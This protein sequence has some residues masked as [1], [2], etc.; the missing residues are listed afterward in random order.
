MAQLTIQGVPVSPLGLGTW[1]LTGRTCEHAVAEAI[2]IGYRHIDTAQ[3]YG[4]EAEVGAGIA[5]S[6]I[7]PAELFVTTKLWSN[8]LTPDAVRCSTEESLRQL[9]LDAVDLLLIHHPFRPDIL[10]DTLGAMRELRDDGLVRHLGVS[11]FSIDLLERA[12][13]STELLA[14]QIEYHPF[15]RQ[16]D[17]LAAARR[18]DLLFQAYSPLARGG[19]T[20]TEV[21]EEVARHLGATAPQVVLRW[22]ID[23]HNV[24]PIPKASSRAHLEENWGALD[25]KLDDDARARL[26]SLTRR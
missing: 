23:Q 3:M 20:G 1:Q 24:V 7:D 9:R 17:Q 15:R 21:I 4:N 22:L 13:G 2:G 26:D 5:A 8:S 12:L 14:I 25:V 18:H 6:G 10:E 11:N 19:A 16:D